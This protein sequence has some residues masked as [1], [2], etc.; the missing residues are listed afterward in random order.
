MADPESTAAEPPVIETARLCLAPAVTADEALIAEAHASRLEGME[1]VTV[2]PLTGQLE[3]QVEVEILSRDGLRDALNTQGFQ[4]DQTDDAHPASLPR[5]TLA[6]LLT[7]PLLALAGFVPAVPDMV[8]G[9]LTVLITL[10]VYLGC[11]MA[12]ATL[13]THLATGIL[14]NRVVGLLAIVLSGV[15]ATML[16]QTACLLATATIPL[17]VWLVRL[18]EARVRHEVRAGARAHLSAA[19]R[20]AFDAAQF[21]R[22]QNQQFANQLAKAAPYGALAFAL[23]ALFLWGVAP[24]G[25]REVS[26]VL[27]R[28]YPFTPHAAAPALAAGLWASGC[29]LLLAFPS[30]FALATAPALFTAATW[31][32]Q[33]GVRVL[34]AETWSAL[35]RTRIVLFGRTGIVT[36]AAFRV[37]DL[38][39]ADGVSEEELLHVVGAVEAGVQHPIAEALTRAARRAHVPFTPAQD[40]WFIPRK[41]VIAEVEDQFTVLGGR[42]FVAGFGVDVKAFKQDRYRLAREGKSIV[43][44]ARDGKLLGVIGLLDKLAPDV[45]RAGKAARALRVQTALVTAAPQD[46]A[47]VIADQLGVLHAHGDLAPGTESR[48][49][50]GYKRETIYRVAA[51]GDGLRHATLL[52]RAHLRVQ[53]DD[54]AIGDADVRVEEGGVRAFMATLQVAHAA[55]IM[56]SW[57]LLLLVFASALLLPLAL[58]GWVAPPLSLLISGSLTFA[59]VRRATKL[60]AFDP[61][62]DVHERLRL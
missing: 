34:R 22:P 3:A 23:L 17:G 45:V 26:G 32:W 27:G 6:V 8:H 24:D 53:R 5:K 38:V 47:R 31:S 60:T 37:T 52:D 44:V 58:F 21:G 61:D 2:N 39:P 56:A 54:D 10:G 48:V 41:G 50:E 16:G 46:A 25:M 30:A 43:Y 55:H 33:Q 14:S 36:Q 42:D 28:W 4:T 7:A 1:S 49:V 12:P 40:Y 29:T 20:H 18:T 9:P 19:D 11:D 59:V 57:N 15:G 35:Y 51:F 62:A 13:R